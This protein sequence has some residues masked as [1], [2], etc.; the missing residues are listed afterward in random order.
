MDQIQQ[1]GKDVADNQAASAAARDRLMNE[2]KH[3]I[4]EA[5]DWLKDAAKDPAPA[6]ENRARFDDTLRTAKTDLRKLEDSLIARSRGA[7]ESANVYV[8]DNPWKSV[9]LGAA[10]GVVVGLLVARK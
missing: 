4:G 6:S 10:I 8:R 2:L 3:A 7:A 5:E 1:N 9:G